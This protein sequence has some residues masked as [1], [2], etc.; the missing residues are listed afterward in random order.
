MKLDSHAITLNSLSEKVQEIP[1]LIAAPL[2]DSIVK[3]C[4]SLE[5]LVGDLK[6][7]LNKFSSSIAQAT[8]KLS[9]VSHSSVSA[10]M[11]NSDSKRDSRTS[12]NVQASS[13][14]SY[15]RSNNIVLFDLPES[16]LLSM[17]SA[18][19]D[20]S[21][22]LIGKAVRVIDAFRLGRKSVADSHSRPRPVL[23]KLESCWDKRLLL[24]ACRKL[25]GYSDHK[26]FICEDLPPEARNARRSNSNSGPGSSGGNSSN[27]VSGKS[28]NMNSN[29]VESGSQ[30][31]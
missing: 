30:N 18:I 31:E 8:D 1:S 19:D 6:V 22:H 20:M 10:Q 23:I 27:T 26:L 25:K 15:D 12:P 13:S 17:K 28:S 14:H 16:S 21:I 11:S 24:A 2:S 4:S 9:N 5:E 29:S 7:Q 3:S